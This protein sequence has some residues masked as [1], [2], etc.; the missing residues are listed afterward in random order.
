[1]YNRL[2]G[3]VAEQKITTGD[4]RSGAVT[5][6][7]QMMPV[8]GYTDS[9]LYRSQTSLLLQTGYVK[10]RWSAQLCFVKDMQPFIVYTLPDGSK[11]DKK[12]TSLQFL[13]GYQLFRYSLPK[14]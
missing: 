10:N 14:H 4:A 12:N 7:V 2:R 13:I 8:K 9:F 6:A 3:A 5:E 11:T 1:M